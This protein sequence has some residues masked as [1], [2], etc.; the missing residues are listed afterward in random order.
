MKSSI[1]LPWKTKFLRGLIEVPEPK[2]QIAHV[3]CPSL[4]DLLGSFVHAV[5]LEQMKGT[6]PEL[7]SEGPF[8]PT[9]RRENF[10]VIT[11]M[12]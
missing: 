4:G 9:E 6:W 7:D 8:P 10:P 12:T 2:R 11:P 5:S 1:S 3:P